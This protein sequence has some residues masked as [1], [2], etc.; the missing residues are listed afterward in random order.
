MSQA[1]REPG[2]SS[3]T[4]ADEGSGHSLSLTGKR[5]IALKRGDPLVHGRELAA[6]RLTCLSQLGLLLLERRELFGG[7][8]KLP[9]EI[10]KRLRALGKLD[11]ELRSTQLGGARDLRLGGRGGSSRRVLRNGRRSRG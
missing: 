2:S 4:F 11:L 7:T 1:I 8:T 3:F 5:E 9:P 6:Q 10:I